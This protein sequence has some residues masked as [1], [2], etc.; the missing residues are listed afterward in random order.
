MHSHPVVRQWMFVL[1]VSFRFDQSQLHINVDLPGLPVSYSVDGGAT[2]TDVTRSS[3]DAS[4]ILPT[5]GDILF[6]TRFMCINTSLVLEK[7]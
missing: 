6:A 2:W 3:I 7:L 5:G 1:C 4:T